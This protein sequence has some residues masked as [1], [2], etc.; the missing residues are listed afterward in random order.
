MTDLDFS[1]IRDIAMM[2]MMISG[3]AAWRRQ[4]SLARGPMKICL[5]L[6]VS[7]VVELGPGIAGVDD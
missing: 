2:M 6:C 4:G 5:G 3:F 1:G 7:S